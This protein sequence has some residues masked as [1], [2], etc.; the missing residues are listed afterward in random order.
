M[1]IF[2]PFCCRTI[3][4]EPLIGGTAK[5]GVLYP[6]VGFDL[7]EGAQE[8]QNGLMSP[9]VIGVVFGIGECGRT[10]DQSRR[11]GHCTR[12]EP[13]HFPKTTADCYGCQ[14][15]FR[16]SS[17]LSPFSNETKVR[18]IGSRVRATA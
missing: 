12:R 7:L 8:R 17:F 1:T 9:F 2:L 15:L 10:G 16:F 14:V 18:V 4:G 3:G 6:E 13:C 11:C 5:F